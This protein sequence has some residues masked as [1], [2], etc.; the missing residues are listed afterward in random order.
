MDLIELSEAF[1]KIDPAFQ[2]KADSIFAHW[3][4]DIPPWTQLL[5]EFG[6]TISEMTQGGKFNAVEQALFLVEKLLTSGSSEVRDSIATG[7]LEAILAES[8]AGKLDFQK[9]VCFMGNKSKDY[10]RAWDKFTG[11]KTPGL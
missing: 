2:R 3:H 1:A 7:L 10:C 6:L 9:I 11:I 8:S 4:P 5:G